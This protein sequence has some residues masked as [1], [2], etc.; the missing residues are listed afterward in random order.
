MAKKR[1]RPKTEAELKER[2]AAG[3]WQAQALTK[4][5]AESSQKITIDIILRIH[6]IFFQKVRPEIAG[7]FRKNGE[8]IKKLK[9][10]TPP[11]GRLVMEQFYVFWRE[12]DTKM[13][14]VP[15]FP[16]RLGKHALRKALEARNEYIIDLAAW[17]QYQITRIHPFCDGNGRMARLMTNLILYR[18]GFQPTD[19]RY[20]GENKAHYLDALCA[21]DYEDD[22]RALKHLIYKGSLASYQ[23]LIER[24]RSVRHNS[25]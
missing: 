14:Q 19:I 5:I 22:Y 18:F 7:R 6:T 17:T 23:K 10:M 16:K 3:L 11:P 21:I 13:A 8:D 15:P 24:Q 20:E 2:E 9:C 1:S 12:F 4:Q 25:R